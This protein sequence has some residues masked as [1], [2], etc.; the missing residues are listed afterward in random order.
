MN[1]DAILGAT[2]HRPWPLPRGPWVALQSW[3]ELLFAH[4]PI[5]L[6]TLRARVPLPL[7]IDTHEGRA[8]ISVA[9]FR[10][11]PLRTRS[12]P[13]S[14]RFPELNLRT[15]VRHGGR[16]G[17]YFFSLDAAS[18]AAVLGA[19]TLFRLNY[20]NAAIH[21][22][23]R[24]GGIEFTSRRLDR[25]RAD[26]HAWYRPHGDTYVAVPGSLDAWLVERYCLFAAREQGRVFRVDIHHLPWVLQ[27]A[28]A[29]LGATTLF[30]AAGLPAPE[31][32]PLL[33]YSLRQDTLTW[34]PD[35]ED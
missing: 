7:E 30:T 33:H 18:S 6:A 2:D 28:E 8:W 19:R 35:P 34:G 12:L 14:M 4:W 32:E 9:A 15:Y 10:I 22:R 13:V 3:R 16:A 23:N 26:F 17:V 11:D 20:F 27:S 29:R 5:D 25:P 24:G 1:T 31:G 21:M